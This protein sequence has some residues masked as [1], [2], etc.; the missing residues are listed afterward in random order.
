MKNK[1]YLAVLLLSTKT[2]A[3]IE[4]V[5][6][7]EHS[8]FSVCQKKL[9]LEIA[10]SNQERSIGMMHREGVKEGT[11]MLFVFEKD[12]D[13]SFW[14]RNVDFDLDIGY[15]DSKGNLINSHTMKATTALMIDSALPQY[16]SNKAAKYAV[17]TVPGFF[18]KISKNSKCKL[19]P[20]PK[21][22]AAAVK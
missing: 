3:Q 12:Q 9:E 17:E 20:L 11:G 13:L 19:S 16:K 2:Y 15:F 1:I 18:L 4:K 21:N 14:M 5:Q 7:L 10:N 6:S 22:S 8:Q